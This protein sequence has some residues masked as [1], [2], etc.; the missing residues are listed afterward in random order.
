MLHRFYELPS[1]SLGSSLA[2]VHSRRNA[3]RV[4]CSH[5]FLHKQDYIEHSVF[6][7]RT[8]GVSNPIRSPCFRHSASVFYRTLL[9]L[10]AVWTVFMDFIP[11]QPFHAPLFILQHRRFRTLAQQLSC[12]ISQTAYNDCLET[13]YAQLRWVTL[14]RHVLPRLLARD[15]TGLLNGSMSIFTPLTSSYHV[16]FFYHVRLLDQAFASCPKFLTAAQSVWALS[17]SQGGCTI[18]QTNQGI[19]GLVGHIPLPTT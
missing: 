10:L 6:A 12:R 14:A 8:T 5:Y 11:T 17:Q 15:Q 18:S 7:A 3:S 13:L 4:S 2:T 16:T 9:P 1:I 19:T